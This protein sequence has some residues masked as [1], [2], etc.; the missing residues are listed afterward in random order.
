MKYD[1]HYYFILQERERYFDDGSGNYFYNSKV[2]MV[3]SPFRISLIHENG[4]IIM[5]RII[6]EDLHEER[7]PKETY[8]QITILK[9][10]ILT[11][12]NLFFDHLARFRFDIHLFIKKGEKPD[13]NL[14]LRKEK[15]ENSPTFSTDF[16][17]L[18]ENSFH[19]RN[20]LKLIA[21][22]QKV[23]L[24][25]QF[26]FLSLYKFLELEFKIKGVWTERFNSFSKKVQDEFNKRKLS[27]KLFSNYLHEI[28][29]KCAHIKTNKDILGVTSLSYEDEKKVKDFT[30]FLTI[31]CIMYINQIKLKDFPF[32]ISY[33]DNHDIDLS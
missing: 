11:S 2:V 22:A 6:K 4:E 7:I 1:L 24:P 5:L 27:T 10:H 20:E 8:N 29:D 21:D 32:K 17:L 9:E 19:F 23:F 15:N 28:R 3:D 26:R 13:L 25:V 12:L 14:L 31:M 18:L 33:I 30:Q 16:T